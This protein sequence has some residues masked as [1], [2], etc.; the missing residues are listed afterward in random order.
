[1][2][3]LYGSRYGPPD[4]LKGT[5]Y[6]PETQTLEIVEDL[7][8]V[9]DCASNPVEDGSEFSPTRKETKNVHNPFKAQ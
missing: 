6:N 1:M 3:G 4:Q 5:N 8:P 2:K 7:K 9:G